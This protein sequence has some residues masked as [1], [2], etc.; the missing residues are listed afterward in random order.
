MSNFISVI[1]CRNCKSRYVEIAEW[2]GNRAVLH[3]RSCN[4]TEELEKFS[5]G[6]CRVTDGELMRARD[7]MASRG[8]PER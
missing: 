5:L 4:A 7:T 6:R 1:F 8:N 3:C 2:D